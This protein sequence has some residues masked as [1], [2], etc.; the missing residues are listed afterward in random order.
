MLSLQLRALWLSRLVVSLLIDA[1]YP[2]RPRPEDRIS[3]AQQELKEGLGLRGADD[4]TEDMK[5][6]GPSA[7][8]TASHKARE[9]KEQA[10]Q[11]VSHARE[12]AQETA[13]QAKEKA[14]EGGSYI[15]GECRCFTPR[16]LTARSVPRLRSHTCPALPASCALARRQA[17]GGQRGR[18]GGP[19]LEWR[20]AEHS[21]RSTEGRRGAGADR[22]R[23]CAPL[24]RDLGEGATGQLV[25]RWYAS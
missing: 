1:I 25:H 13:E 11:G 23:P 21:A 19:R 18:Q 9:T 6:E 24:S 3:S 15:G 14:K 5:Q 12:S 2:V 17:I 22:A 10:K 16:S 20:R 8:E 7:A 4:D